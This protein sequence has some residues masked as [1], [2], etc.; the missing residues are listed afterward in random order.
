MIDNPN[1]NPFQFGGSTPFIIFNGALIPTG[2]TNGAQLVPTS[3]RS[4][5]TEG[6]S[7]Q[8]QDLLDGVALGFNVDYIP[9]LD[10][11]F[12]QSYIDDKNFIQEE[13]LQF[14]W[15]GNWGLPPVISS[16]E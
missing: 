5:V 11:W 9:S 4:V 6:V 3:D 7:A 1:L 8:N 13:Y 10:D 14:L 12:Q 15:E 16:V 2:A